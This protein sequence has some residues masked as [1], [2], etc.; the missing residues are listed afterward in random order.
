MADYSSTPSSTAT[1]NPDQRRNGWVSMLKR[2]NALTVDNLRR[3]LN[4]CKD[5]QDAVEVQQELDRL[6]EGYR[7]KAKSKARPAPP[8]VDHPLLQLVVDRMP[9]RP[10]FS[11]N[12][13]HGLRIRSRSEALGH[14][15]VQINPPWHRQCLVL[16]LDHGDALDARLPTPNLIVINPANGHRHGFVIW[17]TPIIVG[18]NASRK[19]Q[20]YYQDVAVAVGQCWNADINYVGT[21]AHN[22]LH[23]HWQTQ[24]L[25]PEPYQL[26]DFKEALQIVRDMPANHP[27]YKGMQWADAYAVLGRNCSTWEVCRWPSYAMGPSASVEAV[28]QLVEAYNA[29]HNTPPLGFRECLAI[30]KSISKYVLSGRRRGHSMANDEWQIYVEH[31]H[32]PEIQSRR[33]KLGG[34]ASGAARRQSREQERAQ[35]RAMRAEGNSYG[36]IA[37]VT[38]LPES[39][40]K[41]WCRD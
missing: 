34:V 18:P 8:I 3:V 39:T 13:D 11:D 36:G 35:V 32:T 20:E 14:R 28:L 17:E 1:S 30:A 25:H 9:N 16:D 5:P 26:R 10:Y 27:R 38:G 2:N 33:G 6:L 29:M 23:K 24:I 12:L 19:A 4:W 40:V 22:P 7:A 21:T 15:E 31:T 37:L 41:R